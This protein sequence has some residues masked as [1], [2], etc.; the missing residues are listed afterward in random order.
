MGKTN[1]DV[2]NATV[3]WG[4]LD[5]AHGYILSDHIVQRAIEMDRESFSLIYLERRKDPFGID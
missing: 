4:C 2:V 1:V 5:L 3:G